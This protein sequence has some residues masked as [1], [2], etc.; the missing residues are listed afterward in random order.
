M[1][2]HVSGPCP[3]DEDGC[4][5]SANFPNYHGYEDDCSLSID[6]TWTGVLFVE[7]MRSTSGDYF[8]FDGEPGQTGEGQLS[9]HGMAPRRSLVWSPRRSS[10]GYSYGRWKI[11]QVEAL[12]QWTVTEGHTCYID[13]HGCF[14]SES[15]VNQRVEGSCDSPIQKVAL[16]KCLPIGTERWMSSTRPSRMV[17]PGTTRTLRT[18]SGSWK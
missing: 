12:S 3:F 13:R 4:W 17:T 5:T 2:S 6:P 14:E 16:W 15:F 7:Y 18:L 11:C 1:W 9:V 10:T 8:L